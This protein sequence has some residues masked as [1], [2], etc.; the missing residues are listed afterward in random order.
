MTDPLIVVKS[1]E[2]EGAVTEGM[3]LSGWIPVDET[4]TRGANT[5]AIAPSGA[6]TRFKVGDRVKLTDTTVKYFY[7]IG[8]YPAGNYVYLDGG[9]D[10]VLV[11]NPSN[12]YISRITIPQDFPQW[13]NFAPTVSWSG[14][15]VNYTSFTKQYARFAYIGR[16]YFFYMNFYMNTLGSGNH[17][18]AAFSGIPQSNH[19]WAVSATES[20]VQSILVPRGAFQD[21]SSNTIKVYLP[22]KAN[23]T[24]YLFVNGQYEVMP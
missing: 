12:I 7:I 6:N 16:T 10:Y 21:A 17:I 8:F 4:W 1:I 19:S 3:P 11:G 24:G 13:F 22:G 9:T 18:L 14:G 15:T 20:I 5:Y 2:Q 23:N